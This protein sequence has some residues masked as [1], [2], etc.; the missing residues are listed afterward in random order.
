MLPNDCILHILNNLF[1]PDNYEK[2]KINEFREKH[3]KTTLYPMG[4]IT[5]RALFFSCK[6]FHFIK[7]YLFMSYFNDTKQKSVSFYQHITINN[8]NHGPTYFIDDTYNDNRF[9]KLCGYIFYDNGTP[10]GDYFYIL[11]TDH[12]KPERYI[13]RHI[14]FDIENNKL[15]ETNFL[16]EKLTDNVFNRIIDKR[17][18]EYLKTHDPKLSII[19][20]DYY[21]NNKN[22][23]QLYDNRNYPN[24]S[25]CFVDDM[26]IS[27]L[28]YLIELELKCNEKIIF[29]KGYLNISK[30]RTFCSASTEKIINKKLKIISY[31]TYKMYLKITSHELII[32][33][34]VRIQNKIKAKYSWE[35]YYHNFPHDDVYRIKIDIQK[36]LNNIIQELYLTEDI[37]MDT[38]DDYLETEDNF[39][40]NFFNY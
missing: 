31:T 27:E 32:T 25:Y 23:I 2:S 20:S 15:I 17:F 10:Q 16:A 9:I 5:I 29:S 12:N 18:Y 4:I 35:K 6:K 38:N 33:E 11:H 26:H 1:D 24:I 3:K 34:K 14:S 21:D 40:F 8:I 19:N 7:N 37:D 30:I 28:N 36:L 22:K 39:N 13:N